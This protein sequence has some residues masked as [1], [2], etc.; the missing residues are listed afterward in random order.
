MYLRTYIF[1][2]RLEMQ[3]GVNLGCG[4]KHFLDQISNLH[5]QGNNDWIWAFFFFMDKHL[6]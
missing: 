3:M 2:W 1:P 5:T 4:Q 6:I